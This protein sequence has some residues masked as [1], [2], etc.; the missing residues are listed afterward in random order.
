MPFW[1]GN[2]WF[3]YLIFLFVLFFLFHLFHY[4]FGTLEV[5][6]AWEFSMIFVFIS[7]IISFFIFPF[8]LISSFI[9]ISLFGGQLSMGIVRLINSECSLLI[10]L[11]SAFCKFFY[12]INRLPNICWIMFFFSNLAFYYFLPF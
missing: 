10:L 4:L 1:L 12:Q 3:S 11:N 5:N 9:S 7:R 8:L 6:S 2:D